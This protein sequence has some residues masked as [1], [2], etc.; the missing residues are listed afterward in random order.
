MELNESKRN[1][2]QHQRK[3]N[4]FETESLRLAKLNQE[5]KDNLLRTLLAKEEKMAKKV[6]LESSIERLSHQVE[7]MEQE[8][9][10]YFSSDLV[11]NICR[12][13]S[14]INQIGLMNKIQE[15]KHKLTNWDTR[16]CRH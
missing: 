6:A 7:E 8:T 2:S 12:R 13:F 3:W 9:N 10:L 14:S 15:A 5:L 1:L 4:E 11:D 16:S